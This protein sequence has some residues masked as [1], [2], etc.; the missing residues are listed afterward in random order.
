[1]EKVFRIKNEAIKSALEKTTRQYFVGNLNI[2]QLIP[3][4]EDAR[5][6]IG[7]SSYANCTIEA[8]HWHTNQIEYHY[9]LSGCTTYIE[10]DT[11]ER[12]VFKPG[13]FYAIMTGTCFEQ[14][15][16]EGTSLIF[17]K[18]PSTNDKVTCKN[19]NRKDCKYRK[20]QVQVRHPADV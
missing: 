1:M 4:V 14:E 15:L 16:E 18:I 11:G 13:D 17:I 7:I 6:E 9:L 8:P 19:C 5:V 20:L 10:T 2:P 12:H 3:F